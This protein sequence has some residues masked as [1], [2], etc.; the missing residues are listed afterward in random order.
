[1]YLLGFLVSVAILSGANTVIGLTF[2]GVHS[3]IWWWRTW[4]K[5]EAMCVA[6]SAI[7]WGLLYMAET[8]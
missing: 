1:M 2:L 8:Q 4:L 5:M 7:I 6:L 3:H